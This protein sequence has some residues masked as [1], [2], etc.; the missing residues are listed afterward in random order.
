MLIAAVLHCVVIAGLGGEAEFEQRFSGWAQTIENTMRASGPDVQMHVLQGNQVSRD[1]IR[2]TFESI[3]GS[4]KPDDTLAL[5]LIGHGSWDGIDY[6]F[7]IPG[8]DLTDGDFA[9]LLGRVPAG[10]QLVVN[11]TSSSGAVLDSLGGPNRVVIAATKSGTQKNAPIFPRYFVDALRDAAADTDKNEIITASEA[12]RYAEMKTKQ[13]YETQK[14]IATENAVMSGEDS[15]FALL[16]IGS[17]Q[18]A[19]QQPEKR[20]LL[21]KREELERQIDDLKLRK[22]AM[23]TQEYRKELQTLL[24]ELARTQQELDK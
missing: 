13:F 3:R 6:K 12:F 19:A 21:E 10:K 14:R 23:P 4:A 5:L 15:R 24:L 7:T 9:A 2:S 16:R 17:V 22:A 8:P 18:A 11:M 1:A 20:A